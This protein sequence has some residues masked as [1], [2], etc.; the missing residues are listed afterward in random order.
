MQHNGV[1][2][3]LHLVRHHRRHLAEEPATAERVWIAI[4]EHQRQHAPV[5]GEFILRRRL[6]VLLEAHQHVDLRAE[7][8]GFGDAAG[9][10][11]GRHAIA[12]GVENRWAERF[13]GVLAAAAATVTLRHARA[14]FWLAPLLQ[15]IQE[16][17][18]DPSFII[19]HRLRL[20]DA[21]D[22]GEHDTDAL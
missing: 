20:D 16:G 9:A 2:G 18:I 19:T 11:A 7:R 14:V 5:L 13:A 3:V 21:P 22:H 8:Q 17:D 12:L 15:K 10:L 6:G 4:R 1:D